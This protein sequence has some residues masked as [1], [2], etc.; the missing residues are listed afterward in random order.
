[1]SRVFSALSFSPRLGD[2]QVQR[3][4]DNVATVEVADAKPRS[5]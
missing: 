1:M 3:K 4:S 2:E 5:T